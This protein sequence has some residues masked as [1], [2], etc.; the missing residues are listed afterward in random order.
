MKNQKELKTEK[1]VCES[2]GGDKV[3]TPIWENANTGEIDGNG[4]NED[5][6]CLDC[7]EEVSLQTESEYSNENYQEVEEEEDGN[8]MLQ[9]IREEGSM[10][11]SNEIAVIDNPYKG[12]PYCEEIWELGWYYAIDNPS[13]KELAMIQELENC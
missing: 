3:Y 11:Y 12:E 1:L 13:A 10:A 5:H 7:K 6:Y 8:D 9:R 4:G 2:C